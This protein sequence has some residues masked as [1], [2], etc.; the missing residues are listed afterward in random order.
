M[1]F[2][3]IKSFKN[4]LIIILILSTI[5]PVLLISSLLLLQI[6]D[7]AK[8]GVTAKLALQVK[9]DMEV[10][11]NRLDILTSRLEQLALDQNIVLAAENAVFSVTAQAQMARLR[12]EHPEVSVIQLYDTQLWPTESLP[13]FFE[14]VAL[15]TVFEKYPRIFP[16]SELSKLSGVDSASLRDLI[17]QRSNGQVSLRSDEFLTITVIL[18][19]QNEVSS[20][21][22]IKTGFLIALISLPDLLTV[23]E[24]QNQRNLSLSPIATVTLDE[25]RT[26]VVKTEQ[27]LINGET[28]YFSVASLRDEFVKPINRAIRKVAVTIMAVLLISIA[29]A[30]YVSRRFIRPMRQIKTLV[31]SY[32]HGQFEQKI[33]SF[34]F[35]EFQQLSS[36]L[37]DMVNQIEKNQK[38][39]ESRVALRTNELA[40][41]NNE[42]T[43]LLAN[44]RNL[45]SHLVET[46]KMAQLGGLVAGVAH[47]I[48]TPVGIGV[49]A[50]TSLHEFIKEIDSGVNAGTMT[51]TRLNSLLQRSKEC[52]EI[53]LTNLSRSA[54]LISNFKEVAV[55]QS[56]SEQNTFHLYTFLSEI[57]V[58]LY[59]QTRKFHINFSIDIDK[60]IELHSFQGVFAQIFTNFV[61]NSLKHGFNHEDHYNIEVSARIDDGSLYL[62]YSDD[63]AGMEQSVLNQIFEPFYTTKRGKGGTGLGMHI[64]YNLVTQKLEGK[65]SVQSSLGRGTHISISL[66]ITHVVNRVHSTSK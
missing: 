52:T 19:K 23:L 46:E 25:N 54:E 17:E 48:N 20:Q 8:A 49:T 36:V 4:Q 64:V 57:I 3:A 42:L 51:K 16:N 29:L 66:P 31:E 45:Q 63:G 7:D 59:P 60:T 18:S 22:G 1:G 26:N 50:A 35:S 28:I 62:N 47:E 53:L 11:N 32:R 44:Q 33:S 58:S 15:D 13:S 55:S 30:L 39:L 9:S 27:R 37:K 12:N 56:G 41:A 6:T 61:I 40:N 2:S 38:E 10:I 21:S 34:Y 24:D 14:F 5:I 65:I 43:L